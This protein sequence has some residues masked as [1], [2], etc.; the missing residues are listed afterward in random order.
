MAIVVKHIRNNQEYI[1]LGTGFGMSGG[2]RRRSGMVEALTSTESKQKH[3]ITV[4]NSNGEISFFDSND[5]V[6]TKVDDKSPKEKLLKAF[7]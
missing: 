1:L 6:V 7:V 3:I 4:C 2:N 5:V